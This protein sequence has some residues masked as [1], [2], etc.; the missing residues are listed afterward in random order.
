MV[1][2]VDV[3]DYSKK[4]NFASSLKLMKFHLLTPGLKLVQNVLT[5]LVLFCQVAPGASFTDL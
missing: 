1:F 4:A 3:D 2:S 5:L